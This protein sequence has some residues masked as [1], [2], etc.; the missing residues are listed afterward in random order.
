MSKGIT[1]ISGTEEGFYWS[2][3]A[4]IEDNGAFKN[5]GGFRIQYPYNS[6]QRKKA[7]LRST[8]R[9]W[10]YRNIPSSI[11]WKTERHHDWEDGGRMYLLTKEEHILRHRR[12]K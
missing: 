5:K 6:L 11:T 12:E 1:L 9:T 8:D 2:A 10:C 4:F 7:G 3:N